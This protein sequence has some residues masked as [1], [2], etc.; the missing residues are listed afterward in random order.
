MSSPTPSLPR[1]A[2]HVTRPRGDDRDLRG[3][4][5]ARRSSADRL[6]AVRCVL[7]SSL[8]TVC[9]SSVSG[10]PSRTG[11]VLLMATGCRWSGG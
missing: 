5:S 10:I 1:A 7:C 11:G 8:L 9:S 2:R 6:F 3:S 4:Q